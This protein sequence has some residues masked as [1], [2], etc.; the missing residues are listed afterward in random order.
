[1][2]ER[3]NMTEDSK[4]LQK[5]YRPAKLAMKYHPYY[6]GKI[7]V[8]LKVP[9]N[10]YDDFAVW[11]TPGV[12]DP[13]KDIQKNPGKVFDYTNK[14]NN[15][16]IVT[17]GTRVLGL[18]DI[19]PE[20]G[21]PVMEG[22]SL[23]FKYL[24][25]VDAY[26]ICLGTKSPHDIENAV[27]WLQP[28]FGGVNLEDISQPKC[29][30]ILDSLRSDLGIPVW[31]DDQQGTGTVVC[32]GL[33]NAT[34]L[35][36]KKLG[37]IHVCMLGAGAAN[38]AVARIIMEAGVS[39]GNIVMVDTH[40]ILGRERTDLGEEFKAKHEIAMKTNAENRTGGFEE[41]IKDA[42]A[43]LAMSSP[44]PG[45]VSEK[46][47]QMMNNNAIVFA[48]ANPIPEIWPWQAHQAGAKIVATGRSDFPNQVNNSIGFPAIFRGTLDV[49]A[50]MIS[51]EMCIAAAEEIAKVAEEDGLDEDKIIPGMSDWELFPREA[52]AVGSQAVKQGLARLKLSRKQLYERAESI[53]S[54]S[55]KAT[56]VLMRRGLIR[57]L[58]G[59]HNRRRQARQITR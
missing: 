38:I 48:C 13:C 26:P 36:G 41:A 23:L 11:Y 17:D 1:M 59:R 42:D 56:D 4:L 49:R 50:K 53:I 45:T 22:K 28:T 43:L 24:G 37:Q 15:V 55:R 29:F 30:E 20:A 5:A 34:K 12:A 16:A 54:H 10:S 44:G 8:A 2:V 25:G 58:P 7:E 9:V 39:P 47:I 35:V 21:L 27:R 51:D 3:E 33:I 32:A 6:Q 19:G 40:G 46:H 57:S 14:W 52:A 18:G 31:H